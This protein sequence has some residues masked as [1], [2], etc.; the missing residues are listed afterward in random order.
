[1]TQG[2]G[3][4]GIRGLAE[5]TVAKLA[6]TKPW[7]ADEEKEKLLEAV[8]GFESWLDEK[9]EQQSKKSLTE[10]PAFTAAEVVNE[11]KPLG[12]KLQKLKKT[13][14]PAAKENATEE[15]E[16]TQEDEGCGWRGRGEETPAEGSGD[17]TENGRASEDK[18]KD[19]S[20]LAAE[21][22]RHRRL[23]VRS[24]RCTR[25]IVRTKFIHFHS[26]SFISQPPRTPRSR[27]P[28]DLLVQR[29]GA[30]T[31]NKNIVHAQTRVCLSLSRRLGLGH[32][33]L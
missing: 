20:E 16:N 10:T 15:G 30:R 12:A 4:V 23:R 14:A 26:F 5:K 32:L 24:D 21:R 22:I 25:H 8:K 13:P 9:E 1:M 27:G 28:A 19:H 33:L 17:A 6:E 31:K 11:V 7:I 2:G 3:A 18:E 29:L